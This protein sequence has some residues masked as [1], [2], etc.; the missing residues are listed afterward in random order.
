MTRRLLA[1][2]LLTGF[3]IRDRTLETSAE[4]GREIAPA[5]LE[6]ERDSND[7][8]WSLAP[9][10]NTRSLEALS[11]CFVMATER[12]STHGRFIKINKPHSTIGTRE[13]EYALVTNRLVHD[14]RAS[15][16][17]TTLAIFADKAALDKMA[18]ALKKLEPGSVSFAQFAEM[19]A[20][21]VL[22]NCD[23]KKMEAIFGAGEAWQKIYATTT[24]RI[25]RRSSKN[26][27][28]RV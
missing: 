16:N 18:K 14:G 13:G 6:I 19:Q 26:Y 9:G 5:L 3:A 28:G 8:Y 4:I 21:L 12:V 20:R 10:A 7:L 15:E 17:R 2:A 24:K 27:M 23:N 22:Q 1:V 11:L 25:N